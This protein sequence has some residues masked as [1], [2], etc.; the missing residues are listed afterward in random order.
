M[1]LTTPEKIIS[2]IIRTIVPAETDR[3]LVKLVADRLLSH[4]REVAEAEGI[5]AEFRLE[6]SVAKDTWLRGEADLDIFMRVSPKYDREFLA[7]KCLQVARR[8]VRGHKIVERY[9]DHPYIETWIDNIRVNIVPS[10][11]VELRK[12]ISATDRTPYHT[13]YM[14]ERLDAKQRDQVRLLKKFMKG[15]GTYGA[16]ARVGGFS[17]LLCEILVLRYGSFLRTLES[18]GGWKRGEII[19]IAG[20]YT[21]FP[22][23]ALDLFPDPLIAIDPVDAGRNAAAGVRESK[24][25]EFVAASRSFMHKPHSEFFERALRKVSRRDLVE[26][27]KGRPNLL[28]LVIPKIDAVVDVLWSQLYRTERALRKQL[29]TNDFRV[30]RSASWSDE[31]GANVIFFELEDTELPVITKHY[32]PPVSFRDESQ[33]FLSKHLWARDTIGEPWIEDDRWV[34]RKRRVNLEAKEFLREILRGGKGAG[35]GNK[36]APALRKG[37]QIL[38]GKEILK[39]RVLTDEFWD[40]LWRFLRGGE[41][42]VEL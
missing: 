13:D 23:Q 34:V 26:L 20:W 33:R 8:A 37:V 28:F 18:A 1:K 21:K 17:G 15:I 7:T 36:I 25:W 30:I 32:G 6:G 40:Q 16:E 10:F 24:F 9:S 5:D 27:L 14:N 29:Q 3:R 31:A 2:D 4:L 41:N 42:W 39:T 35:V 11:R 19:D 38:A 22:E 12:W